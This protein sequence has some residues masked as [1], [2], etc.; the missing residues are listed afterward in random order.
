MSDAD[1]FVELIENASEDE[2]VVIITPPEDEES[3]AAMK[4]PFTEFCD[5]TKDP[6]RLFVISTSVRI[7]WP[8]FNRYLELVYFPPL[9]QK[10]T[11]LIMFHFKWKGMPFSCVS[12]PKM[13]S[14]EVSDSLLQTEMKGLIGAVPATVGSEGFILMPLD[15]ENC[16]TVENCQG[17]IIYTDAKAAEQWQTEKILELEAA[18]GL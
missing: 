3:I 2:V 13:F 9:S 10:N 15:A 6:T 7:G 17:H 12:V 8:Y 1:N 16:I 14:D 4:I 18:H 11:L 5:M